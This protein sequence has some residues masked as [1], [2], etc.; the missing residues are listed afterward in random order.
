MDKLPE[1]TH[2]TI[3]KTQSPSNKTPSYSNIMKSLQQKSQPQELLNVNDQKQESSIKP[4][5]Q[6]LDKMTSDS[7]RQ[8]Y[9]EK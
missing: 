1:Q 3:N 9:F 2:T 4:D 6:H 8:F 7:F 5:K